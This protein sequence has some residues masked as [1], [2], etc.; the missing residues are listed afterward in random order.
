MKSRFSECVPG[1]DTKC[2]SIHVAV[3][4]NFRFPPEIA[5]CRPLIRLRPVTKSHRLDLNRSRPSP[6]SSFVRIAAGFSRH[7]Q[8]ALPC[9]HGFMTNLPDESVG[10]VIH[11]SP[12]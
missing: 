12:S 7:A 11:I 3:C 4:E 1:V 9:K 8:H 10:R 6:L 2:P 5:Y